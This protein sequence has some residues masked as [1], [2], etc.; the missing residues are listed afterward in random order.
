[1][2]VVQISRIQVRRGQKNSGSGLPQLASG[3]FGWAIDTQ[4][5]FIGN[6]AVSEGAPYVGNTQLLTQYDDLFQYASNY[7]YR[8][9]DGFIDTNGTERSLQDRLDDRV[10]VRSFGVN[11]DGTDETEKLQRAIDQLYVNDATKFGPASRVTLHFE[12][13]EYRFSSTLYIPPNATIVGAGQEKTIFRYSGTG[14]AFKTVNGESQPGAPASD[15]ITDYNNQARN[16]YMTGFSMQVPASVIGIQLENC[17]DSRFEDIG[18]V[19]A[20]QFGDGT[21][22]I[23]NGI[24]LNGL[25]N[26]VLSRNNKFNNIYISNFGN[27]VYSDWDVTDNIFDGCNFVTCNRMV[28]FGINTSVG[29]SGQTVGPFNNTIKNSRF[30]DYDE[31][32][33]YIKNGTGNTSKGNKFYR[34][35]AEGG[36]AT[37]TKYSVIQFDKN[38]NHSDDDW[39]ARSSELASI[40]TSTAFL[41]EVQGTNFTD[42]DYTQS[43]RIGY[44][45]SFTK[46]FNLPANTTRAIEIE[47]LY[48]SVVVDAVRSGTLRI[49]VDPVTDE[50]R[51]TDEYDFIGDQQ[52]AETLQF[53]VETY[54]NNSDLVVD[55]IGITMLNSINN[56]DA[57]FYYRVKNKS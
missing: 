21:N 57:E 8:K 28:A 25:T 44:Y 42:I 45:G 14:A 18:L 39:F 47:Y 33:I 10:S 51:L 22:N 11:A 31:Q 29:L 48:K 38:G 15:A 49:I 34:G 46:I 53:N 54:D 35:G 17:R 37:N 3:E 30:V 20:W 9:N 5:L 2:A 27:A 56:D 24:M 40:Y 55:T 41:P 6:G 43:L 19:S 7:A 12:P 52:Y 4:E 26:A 13:G 36:A 16:I 50:A 23:S 1:M 32:A